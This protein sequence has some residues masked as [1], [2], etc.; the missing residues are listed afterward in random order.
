MK[1][2]KTTR[3]GLVLALVALTLTSALS[4]AVAE[5]DLAT[6]IQDI[7]EDQSIQEQSQALAQQ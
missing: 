2:R 7:T 6:A 3:F 5:G 1:H 4:I